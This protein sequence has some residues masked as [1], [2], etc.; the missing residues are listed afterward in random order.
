MSHPKQLLDAMEWRYATKIFDA[1][2]KI[3]ADV[4]AALEPV[5]VQQ[6]RS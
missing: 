6:L 3:P 1:A 5:L 2:K 4:W